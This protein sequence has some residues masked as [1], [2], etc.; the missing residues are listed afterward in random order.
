MTSQ[1]EIACNVTRQIPILV[2]LVNLVTPHWRSGRAAQRLTGGELISAFATLLSERS[3]KAIRGLPDADRRLAAVAWELRAA[4]LA[5]TA[6]D[7]ASH[8]NALI[9]RYG[10]QPYLVDDVG[11]PFHLHFHGSKETVIESLG[12]EFATAL[13]LIV[14][15]YGPD[16][17]GRCA[18]HQCDAVYVDLT[19]NGSRCYCSARCTA[20]AKTAAYRSRRLQA[21]S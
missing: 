11:Q 15:G 4:L 1:V 3:A 18:A 12:G 6:A 19:R 10:A 8:L 17:F 21:A 14:D 5:E 16:R 13:A 7:K 2:E 20:R 9:R